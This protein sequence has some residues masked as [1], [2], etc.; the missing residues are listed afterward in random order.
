MVVDGAVRGVGST[1]SGDDRSHGMRSA[2]D[3]VGSKSRKGGSSK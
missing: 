2:S 3:L 1:F